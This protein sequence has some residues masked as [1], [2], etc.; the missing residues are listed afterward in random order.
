MTA[1]SDF[2]ITE[3]AGL[4]PA[5]GTLE[6]AAD[7]LI[8]G[9]TIVTVDGDGRAD[10]VTAG[11]HAAGVAVADYDNRTTAP[12]GGGAGAIKTQIMFGVF[13]LEYTGTAPEPGQ[14][15]YVVDN[16]TVSTDSSSGTRGVAGYCVEQ[17][18]SLCYTYMSPVIAG[19]ISK[20]LSTSTGEGASLIG[21]E[22]S[23]GNLAAT[24]VEAALAEIFTLFASVANGEGASLVGVEDAAGN[25]T[26]TDVEAALAEIMSLHASTSNGEGASLIGIE[27][28]GTY[29]AT[30][31][32]EAALQE[33]YASLTSASAAIPV[34]LFALREVDANG[35]VAN[36]AGNGGVLSS[37]SDPVLRGDAAESQEVY[38]AAGN[39]DIVAY[40]TS[41][42][43]DFDSTGDVV[44][45]LTV[46]TD[47]TNADDATFTVESGWDGGALVS[48]TA[49][50]G[51]P[52]GTEHKITATIA[53]ADIAADAERLTLMLTPAA[54]ATDGIAVTNLRLLYTR[55]LLS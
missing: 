36:D 47:N 11:Q 48:D 42:P 46:Y 23:A 38:W 52:S 13:G 27:D 40:Q 9:G 16:Q 54:H 43:S 18:N 3:F 44:I 34:S 32:V 19:E 2:R 45:E 33:I 28:A 30:T 6:Q 15:V 4:A 39:A 49:T 24:N 7:T 5:K 14:V 22:D 21:V 26:A 29:T 41:L 1:T 37:D 35:D 55:K 17:R 50:D 20:L 51:S 53:A 12:E 10:V 25:F 31:D 8:Y